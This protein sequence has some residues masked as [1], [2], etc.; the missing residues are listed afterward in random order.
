MLFYDLAQLIL[1]GQNVLNIETVV[2]SVQL[3]KRTQISK[4]NIVLNKHVTGEG[5]AFFL[6]RSLC[7][8]HQRKLW[9]NSNAKS[10]S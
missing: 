7:C 2:V 5:K 1:R 8:F 6:L 4:K 3:A 9:C 10:P